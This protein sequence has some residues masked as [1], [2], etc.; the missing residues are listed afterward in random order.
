VVVSALVSSAPTLVY[1]GQEVGERGE[2]DS[3]YDTPG[4]TSIFD[5]TGV[6]AHQ[7]WMNNGRLDGGKLSSNEKSL[8]E[9]YRR[10]LNLS[11]NHTALGGNHDNIHAYDSIH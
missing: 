6:P 1:F 5:Y 8:I 4:R 3:G 7:S 11:K 10:L 9:F 2:L